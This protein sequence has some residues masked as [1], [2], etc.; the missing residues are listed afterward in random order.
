MLI[1]LLTQTV[2]FGITSMGPRDPY[3]FIHNTKEVYRFILLR[4]DPE[5]PTIKYIVPF[6]TLLAWGNSARLKAEEKSQPVSGSLL[7]YT[8][9]SGK[10]HT[11]SNLIQ[12][13]Y[14]EKQ[15]LLT[16]SKTWRKINVPRG[17]GHLLLKK[18]IGKTKQKRKFPNLSYFPNNGTFIQCLTHI[19]Q[20]GT[21]CFSL[22]WEK[23]IV[24]R[25]LLH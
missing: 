13:K 7:S 18:Q 9:F 6:T 11:L 10:P 24:T 25:C 4:G 22:F 3:T 17:H 19:K 8:F 5:D 20:H 16:G 2:K 1:R 15:R 14:S 21:L 23:D 12:K